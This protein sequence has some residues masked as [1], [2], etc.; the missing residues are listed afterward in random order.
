MVVGKRIHS[1][2]HLKARPSIL[3][4]I[5][6]IRQMCPR[7]KMPF[8]VA[9]ERTRCLFRFKPLDRNMCLTSAASAIRI[10]QWQ[11]VCHVRFLLLQQRDPK[12]SRAFGVNYVPVYAYVDLNAF[13]CLC[14][15]RRNKVPLYHQKL[16]LSSCFA[17]NWRKE[18]CVQQTK[19][20]P[21]LLP[22]KR[23]AK[24]TIE[25][26]GIQHHYILSINSIASDP[27][28]VV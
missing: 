8:G 2:T 24:R 5:L 11:M 12:E 13:L 26:K 27:F 22:K 18:R 7:R 20:S 15:R 19:P 6:T 28:W 17:L 3:I 10:T 1:H 25:K 21:L 16:N 14:D 9:D 23:P 4:R